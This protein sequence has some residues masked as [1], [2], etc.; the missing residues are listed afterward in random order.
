MVGPLDGSVGNF[1][2]SFRAAGR[3]R[4]SGFQQDVGFMPV[5]I[6][7]DIDAVHAGVEDDVLHEFR[8][9]PVASDANDAAD[10]ALL[11]K[12][13][14]VGHGQ[15]GSVLDEIGIDVPCVVVFWLIDES[16]QQVAA[17]P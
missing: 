15:V 14:A 6:V 12:L 16:L 8:F 1:K 3:K 5:H 11:N 9:V 2:S 7:D 4:E 10:W 13:H 17:L